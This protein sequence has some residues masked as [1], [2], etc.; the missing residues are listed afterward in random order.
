VLLVTMPFGAIDRPAL[1]LS[2]L[3]AVARRE[4]FHC[5]VRYLTL[6]FAEFLGAP[7]YVWL[8]D[9]V[10]YESFAGDWLFSEALYGSRPKVDDA[11][12]DH[13]LRRRY[14]MDDDVIRR[15]RRARAYVEPFLRHCMDAVPWAQYDVVGFT[16]TFQQNLASLALAR[17][18]K[19]RHPGTTIVFGGANWEGE[20]GLALHR[21]FRFVDV[22]CS[23][24]AEESF[25]A[26][27]HAL[28]A[29]APLDLVPGC[30]FRVGSET[31][32]TPAH[33]VEDLDALPVPCY[34]DYFTALAASSCSVDL[35]PRLLLE[36]ARGCWWGDRSHCTFCG[37][38]GA[39]MRFRSKSPERVSAEIDTLV[40]R[41]GISMISV[42]DN[43]L[44]MRYFRTLLPRLAEGRPLELFWEIKA[45]LSRKQVQTLAAA[46]VRSVQ[47]GIE[48]MSDQVLE[49]LAKGTTMRRNLQLLKWG[50][51]YGVKIEWNLLFGAPGEDPS[52]Y[53]R[54]T[55][56]FEHLGF[57]DPPGACGPVR[58]DRFSPYHSDPSH[59]GIVNVRATAAYRYTYDVPAADL[60][61]IAYYFDFDYADGRSP[62]E[63]A[64]TA[65]EAVERWR[66]RHQADGGLWMATT[67]EGAVTILDQRSGRPRRSS[68]LEGWKAE[69]FTACDRARSR[70]EI[71]A[72]PSVAGVDAAD[73]TRFL[74]RC[75][76]VGVMVHDGGQWLALPV[77]TPPRHDQASPPARRPIPLAVVGA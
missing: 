65:V 75:V 3:Q 64:M 17:R 23:G 72:L 18:V 56:L 12:E 27:L 60:E 37:L 8:T 73:V 1:G 35:I 21:R 69:V 24:E 55:A 11:Y 22:A 41:Y 36:T 52:E 28:A 62:V 54:Q 40:D 50:R 66:Q 6:P 34:D 58:M 30:V 70:A 74:D 4:G 19:A 31:R 13:I 26:L 14:R 9:Q 5:D 20:M 46:G 51:E 29:G 49:L 15:L 45:N 67:P 32:A 59:Y 33:P 25:P 76:T 48:S 71:D 53:D 77:H 61:R 47:P 39:T 43:I 7:E 42:V 63:Y 44:D 57:L 68:T 16:S 38:N 10:P 2:L